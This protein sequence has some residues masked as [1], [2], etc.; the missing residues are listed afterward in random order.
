MAFAVGH[1]SGGH[2]NPAVTI[3]LWVG[4][5]F[6]S[7]DV[8]ALHRRPA[9]RG[10][11]S[12]AACSWSSPAAS[13][14]STPSTGAAGQLR[15]QRLRRLLAGRLL[16]ARLLRVRGRDDGVLPLVIMGATHGRAP[17]GFAPVAIGLALT[18][19]HLISIP[20]TNTSVNPARSFGVALF[21][22]SD[23]LSQLWLFI[24]APIVGRRSAALDLRQGAAPRRRR[25]RHRGRPHPDHRLTT[26]SGRDTGAAGQPPCTSSAVRL[27]WRRGPSRRCGCAARRRRR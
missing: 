2:F 13:T 18:L 20:V 14:A 16:A 3:G 1:I 24:V 15:H 17:E 6:E 4:K 21:A 9:R 23:A 8:G 19:I 27:R 26:R 25:A 22:G 12:P 7:K 11:R 5:R 10:G